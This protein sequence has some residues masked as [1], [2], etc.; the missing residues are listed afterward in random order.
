[1]DDRRDDACVFGLEEVL[2][3]KEKRNG[4]KEKKRK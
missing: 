4:A 3:R 1:V 2:S